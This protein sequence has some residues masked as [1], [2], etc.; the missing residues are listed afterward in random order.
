MMLT[1]LI[2]VICVSEDFLPCSGKDLI[3][4]PLSGQTQTAHLLHPEGWWYHT[5][6]S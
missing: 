3:S 6:R 4:D 2:V 1:N 5:V